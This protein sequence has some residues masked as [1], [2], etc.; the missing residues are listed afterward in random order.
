MTVRSVTR[1][2]FVTALVA[3]GMLAA[4]P[5]MASRNSD[6]EAYVQ[7]NA[8]AALR[9]L[10]DR[11]V[12]TA[13][14][15][16]TFNQLMAQFADMPRIATYVLGRY[17]G[18]LRADATLRSDW[19]RSFQDYAIAVYE[20]QLDRY[21]GGAVRVTGSIERTP[22]RDVVVM[23]QITPR[24]AR[25]ALPVQWRLLRAGDG[26]KVV[27][28]SLLIDGNEIWLAQQQQGEFLAALDRNNGDIRALMT[29]IRGQTAAL[30]QG[31]MAR[32]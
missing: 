27:D 6:A 9:T 32:T 22:G 1:A 12:N 3:L 21:N 16:Q 19:M 24:G 26:W 11:T 25:Q 31:L 13:Q 17:S 15:Q 8:A 14:R 29:E 28:V 5:A 4:T 23:S 20:T 7:E 30:R 2:A 18:Q 10:G